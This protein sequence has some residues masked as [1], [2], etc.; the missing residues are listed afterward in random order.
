MAELLYGGLGSR[1]GDSY[2]FIEGATVARTAKLAINI[3]PL[4]AHSDKEALA[5]LV[6]MNRREMSTAELA[7]Q[8]RW[9]PSKV[10][11]R[12]DRWS[13]AGIINVKPGLG[14]RN[15][16]TPVL[17]AIASTTVDDRVSTVAPAAESVNS[18][19]VGGRLRTGAKRAEYVAASPAGGGTPT[20]VAAPDIDASSPARD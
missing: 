2:G 10:R 12:L 11:R 5:W 8:W 9:S 16:I 18:S 17:E 3:V 13:S 7:D 20:A 6:G 15:V 14:G 1:W 19:P 4:R